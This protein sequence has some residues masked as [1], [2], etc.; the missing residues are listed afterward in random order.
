MINKI[1]ATAQRLIYLLI[2]RQYNSHKYNLSEIAMK[3]EIFYIET[4]R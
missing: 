1:F 2:N 3:L 4:Y